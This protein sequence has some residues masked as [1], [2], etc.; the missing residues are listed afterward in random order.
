MGP[1]A[2]PAVPDL[3]EALNGDDSV[4]I[5]VAE[6]LGSIGSGAKPAV[7]A[8]RKLLDHKEEEIRVIAQQAIDKIEAK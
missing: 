5:Y 4:Q 8:L 1:A 7:P 6:A 2:E 3:I